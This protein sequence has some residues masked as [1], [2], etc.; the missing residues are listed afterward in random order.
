MGSNVRRVLSWELQ[1][2]ALLV[3]L[4]SVGMLRH[5]VDLDYT[6]PELVDL[7][8]YP[9]DEL[10]GAAGRALVARAREDLRTTGCASFPGFLGAAALADAVEEAASKAPA[11]FATDATH[12]AYQL[13][14]S[15]SSLPDAH[16]RNLRMRTRVASTAYDELAADGALRRLYANDVFLDLVGAVTGARVFRLD[17]A[18]G[19]ASINVFEP[20]W[21]HAWHYDESEFTVTLSLQTADRGGAFELT[22]P[23]RGESGGDDAFAA[24][25]AVVNARSAYAA[26]PRGGAAP[27]V[28]T[29]P[30][31]PGTLQS[32][33]GRY[34]LHRVSPVEGDAT[35]LVAVY[36]FNRD[37]GF[38]NTPEV[39][40]MFW[41]RALRP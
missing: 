21:E 19:A 41:G 29:A 34:S 17:D 31:E 32:F 36:C 28:R 30:F 23:L 7:S 16:V 1:A 39:Q 6:L 35:R 24:T 33:A 25:A 15:D 11:A 20:A 18:L 12:N 3:A 5:K 27:P 9:I 26:E 37:P 14:A 8:R 13:S 22:P 2:S 38:V 4:F 10:R 40:R